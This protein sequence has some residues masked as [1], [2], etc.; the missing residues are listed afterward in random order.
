MHRY[1]AQELLPRGATWVAHDAQRLLGYVS[2]STADDNGRAIGWVDHLYLDPD[3]VGAGIGSALMAVALRHTP[4]AAAVHLRRQRR[5][6]ALL[7]AARL[8]AQPCGLKL[9][10]RG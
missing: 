10:L 7:R 2:V 9:K 6:T 1:V 3:R 4:R 5:R 8:R